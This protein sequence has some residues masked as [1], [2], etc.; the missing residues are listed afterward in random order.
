[1]T[2][3][4]LLCWV[5]LAAGAVSAEPSLRAGPT[6][7]RDGDGVR[8]RFALSEAADVE[9]AVLDGQ[10]QVVRHLAA[11][12]VGGDRA[13]APLK[14][15]SL[16]QSI[17]WDG[18]D[19]EGKAVRGPVTV[20]L[21]AG[22]Q[23][24][25]GR[26]IGGSPYRGQATQEPY[27]GSLPGVAVD[28]EGN[29]YVKMMSDVGSHGNTRLWPWQVRKFD[30]N[31]DYVRTLLPYAPSTPAAKASGW[32]LIRSADGR[33]TPVNQSSLYPVF[34][35][36]GS[37]LCPRLTRRG[38]LVFVHSQQRRL[39]FFKVDG[40]NE[41]RQVVLW[42]KKAKM[43]APHWLDFDV[44]FSPD[45]RYAYYANVA[46]TVYDGKRPEDVDANW[47]NGRVYRHDISRPGT[48]PERFHDL[49]LPD[50][51][52]K[53]Y[54]MPSAW[55]KRTAAAG[56]DTDPKGNVYIC[57]QVNQQVVV[58]SP[59][60]RKL[61]AI[62]LPW[63]DRVRVNPLTG[64]LY[65]VSRK[66]SRGYAP[67]NR[68]LKVTGR[69]AEAKVVAELAMKRRGNV[70]LTVDPR[71]RP[72]VLWVLAPAKNPSG[73]GLL[74][75]ED[76][77]EALAV[78]K[79][80]FGRHPNALSFAGNLAVDRQ[81]DLVYVT[82][83]RGKVCRYDGRTGRGGPVKL[84]ASLLAVGPDGEIVRVS[85]W[86]SPL[87]RYSRR[88]EPLAAGIDGKNSFGAF[89]GRA[90]R[91]CSL[92][93]LAVDRRGRVWTLQEGKGMYV[94][95]FDPGGEKALP[96][97][98]GLQIRA[99][100]VRVDR[101][102]NLYVGYRGLPK[103]HKP[104]GGYEKDEAYRRATG[105]VL[106]FSPRGG[107]RLKLAPGRKPPEGT[108]M[109]FEGVEAVYPGLAP[110]S[111]WRCAGSCV[112][113]KPRFDVDGF[114]RII[115]PNA[116]TFSVIVTDSAGNRL[117]E[118]GHYGNYDAQGPGSA[119]PKP[120][121]PLGWPTNARVAGDHVYVADVLNHRIARVDLGFA[122]TKAV[123]VK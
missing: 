84:A 108:V 68:L 1:M 90:G 13:A 10:G 118:F 35:T 120:A 104:P 91:G 93:G 65:V 83:T 78:T 27:S 114:G 58:V 37:V 54:W 100:C 56:I 110:F 34:S 43:P 94:A 82:D 109:G 59:E 72:T 4:I 32:E 49:E 102:G 121:I 101:E 9:I 71:R 38:E 21:R 11:G 66:V 17:R 25:L 105:S 96:I 67:P 41:V 40:S 6:A 23:P 16:S 116:V 89:L 5:L 52:R 60:G 61:N 117:A 28:R 48:V 51:R 30:P 18:A 36:F 106:K 73:Q 119:E 12:W 86:H 98:T 55:D 87:A 112:C 81:A 88:M 111:E 103:G 63:P 7:S 75:V 14:P 39:T 64:D 97:V 76:R 70:E 29:V 46:G 85:G 44:A 24:K 31:G 19:D 57:D 115:M 62:G 77:G 33:L 74:R 42:P 26:L 2:S 123:A 107:R 122:V 8:V 79:D 69:G 45:G 99:S 53:K 113:T 20:R 3:S 95:A 92:G 50:F 47:P 22:M 15:R 80:A